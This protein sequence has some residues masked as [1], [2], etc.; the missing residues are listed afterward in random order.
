[1]LRV[2]VC[3]FCG[4]SWGYSEGLLLGK[5]LDGCSRM[6]GVCVWWWVRFWYEATSCR[7][8]IKL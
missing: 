5:A 2:P 7:S 8:A 1:M 3:G 6:A 4:V